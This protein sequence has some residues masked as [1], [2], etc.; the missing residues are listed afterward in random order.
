MG[1]DAC[2]ERL[3][4]KRFRN[5]AIIFGIFCFLFF[6]FVAF[7]NFF[8]LPKKA[9]SLVTRELEA[10]TGLKVE[11]PRLSFHL[12]K[13]I[14]LESLTLRDPKDGTT[15]FQAHRVYVQH[16]WIP[17]VFKKEF[18]ASSVTFE[19]P[20]FSLT[21]FQDGRW[22]VQ[23]FWEKAGQRQQPLP[24]TPKISIL[25][26][27]LLFTDQTLPIPF[28]KQLTPLNAKF[29]VGFPAHLYFK[30]TFGVKG[31]PLSVTVAGSRSLRKESLSFKCAVTH[32]SLSDVSP[33]TKPYLPF[34]ES[35]EGDLSFE[36]HSE[37]KTDVDFKKILFD[38]KTKLLSQGMS[39]ETNLHLAGRLSCRPKEMFDYD[40]K[41]TLKGG[42]FRMPFLEQPLKETTGELTLRNDALSLENI[43]ATLGK[44][45]VSLKGKLVH[46]Q[47]PELDV[48]LSSETDMQEFLKTL[49]QEKVLQPISLKGPITVKS[50][51]KGKIN[52]PS[53]SGMVETKDLL[54]QGIPSF[55]AIEHL[56]GSLVFTENTLETTALSGQYHDFPFELKG[57]VTD[58]KNPLCDLRL[59]FT[60]PLQELERISFFKTIPPKI[61]PTLEGLGQWDLL[62]KGPLRDLSKENVS[63]SCHLQNV[64]LKTPLL[65][66]AVEKM[67]GE[68]ALDAEHLKVKGITGF[69]SGNSFLLDGSLEQGKTPKVQFSLTTKAFQLSSDFT[70]QE[71]DLRPF[72]LT[73]RT[74]TSLFS[75][76]G[77]ILNYENPTLRLN[78]RWEGPVEELG[79]FTLFQEKSLGSEALKGKCVTQFTLAG[80][81]SRPDDIT[82]EGEFSSDFLSY[83][84]F[85]F[86]NL[87]SR[88]S[89]Q[90]KTLT[91]TQFSGDFWGGRLLSD[92]TIH[93]SDER[94]YK[95]K[96]ELTQARLSEAV[97]NFTPERKEFRGLL[98]VTLEAEGRMTDTETLRG[99][100]WV[101]VEEGD[102]FQFPILGG[103][104]P[105]LRP[106]IATLYPELDERIVFQ[107]AYAHF[108]VKEKTVSTENLTLKGDR[109]ILYGEGSVGFDQSVNFHI[110]IQFTD[111]QILD[112]PTKISRLKNIFINEKGVLSGEV[113]MSGTLSQPKYRYVPLSLDRIQ[114]IFRSIFQ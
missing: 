104:T 97:Q 66:K 41:A 30:G 74:P 9:K 27:T 4:M 53:V 39:G 3:P 11:L 88:Y 110:G 31:S 16:L 47:D 62:V 42:V 111:P 59:H 106:I 90:H 72:T 49:S 44:T 65:P 43:Q 32:F 15:L 80:P 25:H 76:E 2:E 94:D 99:D 96:A 20:I 103:L 18:I 46:L 70:V 107:E 7:L 109:A 85:R 29:S 108:N 100:G 86:K 82:L 93:L 64:T 75:L 23:N 37:G 79:Q 10:E 68:L 60:Q 81:K 40:F 48:T 77:E 21:R 50:E 17:L 114:N 55:G 35:A 78:G 92:A 12:L 95:V 98:S 71:K 101:K 51:I 63:G 67:D 58:L 105:V 112:R 52:S 6:L 91:L 69:Y 56:R 45:P 19:K 22:N 28:S 83:K 102:L 34:L 61:R 38:G 87:S 14:A 33:Y 5:F 8:Y 84:S 54:I 57:K 89:F 13:G 24:F 73:R 1:Y 36:M 26:G 113:R